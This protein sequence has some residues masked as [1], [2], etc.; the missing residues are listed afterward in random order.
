MD[1]N[2]LKFWNYSAAIIKIVLLWSL[3]FNCLLIIILFFYLLD[4]K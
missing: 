4:H 2:L 3:S 1:G